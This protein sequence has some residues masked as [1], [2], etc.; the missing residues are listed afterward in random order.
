MKGRGG[1]GVVLKG[2][3]RIGSLKGHGRGSVTTAA[4][5]D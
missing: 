5:G 3:G 1:T 2:Y 4:R